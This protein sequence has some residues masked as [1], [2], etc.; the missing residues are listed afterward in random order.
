MGAVLLTLMAAAATTGAIGVTG[1][2]F[3]GVTNR[4]IT[5]NGDGKND[6]VTFRFSNPRDSAGSV[7][8]YDVRGQVIASIAVNPTDQ[9]ATWDP[10]AGGQSS[11]GGF[12]IYVIQVEGTVTTGVVVVIK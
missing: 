6:T 11:A 7:K 10:R 5:P 12:Y 8:I 2:S 1:F 4:Y 3:T 9:S